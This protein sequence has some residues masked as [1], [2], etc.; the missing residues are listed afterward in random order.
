MNDKQSNFDPSVGKFIVASPD[1]VINGVKVGR[2]LQTY[3]RRDFG[4][5]FGFAYDVSGDGRT[6]VRGGY[7]MFWNF[8]PG[9]TS[10]SKAQNPPFLQATTFTTSFGTNLVLSNGLPAPPGV[11]PPSS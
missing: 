3:G 5:R 4:P 6:I 11:D 1:A 7:G 8:T 2:Y 9:G 10:S